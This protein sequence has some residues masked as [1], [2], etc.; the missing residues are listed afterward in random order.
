MPDVQLSIE[1]EN[2]EGWKSAVVTRSIETISGSFELGFAERFAGVPS[3][4]PIRPGQACILRVNGEAVMTGHVDDV[5]MG[6]DS[7]RHEVRVAGRD[8]TGDLVDCSAIHATGEWKNRD[9][10]QI[11]V[12][13]C[14]PFGIEVAGTTD[15]G[16]PFKKFAIQEGETA[17]ETIERAAR[18]RGV[19]LLSDGLGG[20]EIGR[21]TQEKS[22]A[23]LERGVNIKA[24]AGRFSHRGRFS[25]YIVKGQTSGNDLFS[26]AAAGGQK[27]E[28]EDKRITRYRP[29]IIIAE[30]GG[31]A[32]HFQERAEWERNVRF[33]R[34]SQVVY[35]VVGWDDGEK[36]WRP[37]TRVTVR[38]EWEGLPEETMLISSVKLLLDEQGSRAELGVVPPQAF[39][40]VALPEPKDS[41]LF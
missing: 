16:D 14:A 30:E 9:L 1:G 32:K 8:A 35:T 20:L 3:T 2:Y 27:G 25:K 6:Y 15:V 36:L 41:Q 39:D 13:V 11:A 21:V 17:F 24:A 40:R 12:D 23:V 22:S 7:A 33:G 18:M 4:R 38:D 10:F 5:E 19:L 31:G 26:G 29:R 28:A 34:G 37:N